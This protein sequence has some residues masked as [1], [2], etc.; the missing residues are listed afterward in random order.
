MI[1]NNGVSGDFDFKSFVN[2][3]KGGAINALTGAVMADTGV[4]SLAKT[5][6]EAGT[7]TAG[8]SALSKF[9]YDHKQSILIGGGTIAG[10][11]IIFLLYRIFR[12]TKK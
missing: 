10:T 4:Q 12:K 6:V 9:W 1:K 2:N 11:G 7:I 3:L 8:S 5:T